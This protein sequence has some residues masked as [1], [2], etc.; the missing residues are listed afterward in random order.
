M[1]HASIRIT[2]DIYGHWLEDDEDNDQAV[3]K[4]TERKRRRSSR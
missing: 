4:L 1:G 3:D 2:E